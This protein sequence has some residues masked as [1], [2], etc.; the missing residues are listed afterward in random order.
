LVRGYYAITNSDIREQQ[1]SV[2]GPMLADYF[3]AVTNK[4][5]GYCTR[6]NTHVTIFDQMCPPTGVH[7]TVV[8]N[9]GAWLDM[10][11]PVLLPD[12]WMQLFAEKLPKWQSSFPVPNGPDSATG[13][14]QGLRA[15]AIPGAVNIGGLVEP[16]YYRQTIDGNETADWSDEVK[17][18]ERLIHVSGFGVATYLNNAAVAS[19][20]AAGEVAKQ[21]FI[22]QPSY[23]PTLAT[24]IQAANTMVI[25]NVDATGQQVFQIGTTVN[26]TQMR[27]ILFGQA[28]QAIP[29]WQLGDNVA[30]NDLL[31]QASTESKS[32]WSKYKHK[33]VPGK[34]DSSS[35]QPEQEGESTSNT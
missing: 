21:R 30:W 9:T 15:V 16:D 28:R 14:C 27:R 13:F 20:L 32:Q 4:G 2:F 24:G 8:D 29:T 31:N 10:T 7:N 26:L 18:N 23:I 12:V 3:A 17:W 34:A 5:L 19:T 35:S 6:G 1:Y 22:T 11:I 33:R 25:P